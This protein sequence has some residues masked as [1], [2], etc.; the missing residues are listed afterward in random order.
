MQTALLF[1][2]S[3]SVVSQTAPA[4]RGKV[5]DLVKD[6]Y[7]ND[8][9]TRKRARDKLESAVWYSD[10]SSTDLVAAALALIELVTDPTL[11]I[12]RDIISSLNRI[13]AERGISPTEG[14]QIRPRLSQALQKLDKKAR[15]KLIP[16]TVAVDPMRKNEAIA[17]CIDTLQVKSRDDRYYA[18]RTLVDLD[19]TRDDGVPFL[20]E[21]L[22]RPGG[23]AAAVPHILGDL[24]PVAK[25][26]V[27]A[28]KEL[29]KHKDSDV[30]AAAGGALGRIS[31]ESCKEAI[32]VLR[33]IL[34]DPNWRSNAAQGLAHFGALA[35]EAI[36]DLQKCVK[37]LDATPL[38]DGSKERD[39]AR[40]HRELDRASLLFALARID[41]RSR[42]WVPQLERLLRDPAWVVRSHVLYTLRTIGPQAR[43]TTSSIVKTIK[44][45]RNHHRFIVALGCRALEQID[46]PADQVVPLLNE[47]LSDSNYRVHEAAEKALAKICR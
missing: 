14:E 11:D 7:S 24:G 43:A 36:P 15:L 13:A 20:I 12:H 35:Q 28:L 6:F 9:E 33:R 29:L 5:P 25:V 22:N 10:I 41:Q 3:G 39:K 4:E 38:G 21:C 26:S 42:E 19:P 40:R 45:E 17:M 23:Y 2:I 18:A 1:L 27:P 47:L 8:S 44:E 37:E 31:P 32:P 16:V 46:P 30:R 34:P